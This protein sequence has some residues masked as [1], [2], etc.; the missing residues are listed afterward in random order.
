MCAQLAINR[1]PNHQWSFVSLLRLGVAVS[2]LFTRLIC[3]RFQSG[4]RYR[5]RWFCSAFLSL[6][7]CILASASREPLDGEKSRSHV[8]FSLLCF[9]CGL[10]LSSVFAIVMCPRDELRR[11]VGWAVIM[12]IQMLRRWKSASIIR[13]EGRIHVVQSRKGEVICFMH[14]LSFSSFL[15]LA[16]G[17]FQLFWSVLVFCHPTPRHSFCSNLVARSQRGPELF[18]GNLL[19]AFGR[20]PVGWALRV[21]AESGEV[22]VEQY[23]PWL[24]IRSSE[25]GEVEVAFDSAHQH[26]GG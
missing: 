10:S 9:L 21:L 14:R 13:L 22:G 1:A 12:K 23:S 26:L 2:V 4:S 5:D 20:R 24:R 16:G 3:P 25:V 11:L 7:V 17:S 18:G 15:Y 8:L 19:S 6:P